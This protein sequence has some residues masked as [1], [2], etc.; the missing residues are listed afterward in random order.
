MSQKEQVAALIEF[1]RWAITKSAFE[2]C[3]LDGGDV[4][5]EAVRLGLL[6]QVR[7]TEPCGE[8]CA[9]FDFPQTCHRFADFMKFTPEA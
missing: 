2:G 3:D 5:D 4:Q 7:A 1:V 6:R 9:C 8:V